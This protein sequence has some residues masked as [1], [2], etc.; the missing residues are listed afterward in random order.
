MLR[1]YSA[2]SSEQGEDGKKF[3]TRSGET[4]PLVDLLDEVRDGMMICRCLSSS[5]RVKAVI[6]VFV[7]SILFPPHV[8]Y[9]NSIP[10]FILLKAVKRMELILRERMSVGKCTLKE[11]EVNRTATA[12]GYGAVKYFDLRQHPRFVIECCKDFF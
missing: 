7:F 2:F 9:F 3:K 8:L 12:I 1:L 5:L 11:D 10:I 4:V 6:L